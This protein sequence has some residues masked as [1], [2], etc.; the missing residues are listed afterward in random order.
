MR[1]ILPAFPDESVSY[2]LNKVILSHL[3]S[4]QKLM[5]LIIEFGV[6]ADSYFPYLAQLKKGNFFRSIIISISR[7]FS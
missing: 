4:P 5:I 2:S 6:Y 7:G 3:L 1:R